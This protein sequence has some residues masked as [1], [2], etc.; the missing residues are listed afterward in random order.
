MT[1]YGDGIPIIHL[2]WGLDANT[3]CEKLMLYNDYYCCEK[4][5][6]ILRNANERCNAYSIILSCGHYHT[7]GYCFYEEERIKGEKQ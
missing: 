4:Y 5:H 1:Y 2:N 6:V 7:F 3:C